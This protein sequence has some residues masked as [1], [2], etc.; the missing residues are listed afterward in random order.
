[1]THYTHTGPYAGLPICGIDRE[2]A[3]SRGDTFQHPNYAGTIPA[4]LCK[5]C[6]RLWHGKKK[7]VQPK[8]KQ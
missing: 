7:K 4:G 3:T 1:M 2:F 5:T 6:E 8:A